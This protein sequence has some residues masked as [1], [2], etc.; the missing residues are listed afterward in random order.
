M[1]REAKDLS[2]MRSLEDLSM[3]LQTQSV[4]DGMYIYRHRCKGGVDIHDIFL[5]KSTF[6]VLLSCVGAILLLA[7]VCCTLLSKVVYLKYHYNN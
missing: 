1:H 6:R 4:S 7:N 2:S 5:K 3:E